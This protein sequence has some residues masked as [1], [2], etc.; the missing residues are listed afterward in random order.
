MDIV[1]SYLWI[2][3]GHGISPPCMHRIG[4]WR[5]T[6]LMA[7]LFG[8]E[9]DVMD[10]QGTTLSLSR[11]HQYH[12]SPPSDSLSLPAFL[13][14]YRH[15]CDA[16]LCLD[17]RIDRQS[18]KMDSLIEESQRWIWTICETSETSALSSRRPVLDSLAETQKSSHRRHQRH[19]SNDREALDER[20]RRK[21]SAGGYTVG[22]HA[23]SIAQPVHIHSL[24][25]A[26]VEGV[27]QHTYQAIA[28]AR[29]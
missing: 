19:Q 18:R 23:V 24:I 4:H 2:S 1:N 28:T 3:L 17:E 25:I 12:Q 29:D 13:C 14:A 15:Q 20:E 6:A 11:T 26:H 5:F 9:I 27:W 16:I 10:H 21:G 22:L 8:V 7:K